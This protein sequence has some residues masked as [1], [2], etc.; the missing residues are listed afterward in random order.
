[1]FSLVPSELAIPERILSSSN[2]ITRRS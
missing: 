2:R 1:M